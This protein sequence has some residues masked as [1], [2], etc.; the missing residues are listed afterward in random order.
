MTNDNDTLTASR[1]DEGKDSVMAGPVDIELTATLKGSVITVTGSGDVDIPE[2]QAATRFNFTLNDTTKKE[3]EFTTLD[4]EDNSTACPPPTGQNSSQI[5]G[6]QT[7]NNQTPRRAAFTDKNNNDPK[8][9]DLKISYAWNFRCND[10]AI[11]VEPF[12]PIITNG[13]RG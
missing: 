5:E 9:G 11:T 7:H 13:G 2:G 12:D 8:Q 3:V 1:Q 10:P 4:A 6:V